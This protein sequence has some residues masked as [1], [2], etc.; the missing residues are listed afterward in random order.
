MPRPKGNLNKIIEE[1]EKEEIVSEN[2]AVKEP[3]SIPY[4]NE[5]LAKLQK[6]HSQMLEN[7]IKDIGQLEVV[8]SK[9]Q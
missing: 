7:G 6:L 9:L 5:E 2:I 3:V 4:V 1:I 8:I